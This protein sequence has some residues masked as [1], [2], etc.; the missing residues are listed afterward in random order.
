MTDTFPPSTRHGPAPHGPAPDSQ[1]G[2]R[3]GFT[4]IELIVYSA[5]VS[6]L[7]V[8]TMRVTLMLFDSRSKTQTVGMMQ[9]QLRFAMDRMSNTIRGATAIAYGSSEFSTDTG[10][11]GL[12]LSDTALSPTMLSVAN[13]R[14]QVQEGSAAPQDL[15]GTGV[16][17]DILRFTDLSASST[18]GT[19][20]ITIHAAAAAAD[21]RNYED[22]LTLETSVSL[23]Q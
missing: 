6:I 16:V 9:K 11:I 21:S 20:K 18:N 8:T 3:A 7:L 5:L 23:R 22:D 15:T 17:V 10:Q 1:C 14:L 19:V 13:G 12:T 4:L 2:T